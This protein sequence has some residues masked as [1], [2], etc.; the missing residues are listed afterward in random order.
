MIRRLPIALAISTTL[1]G[2]CALGP[3][4][5]RPATD[6]P[7]SF[8]T[9]LEKT[10]QQPELAD[11]HWREVFVDSE[12]QKLIA[13]ALSAGPDALLALARIREAEALAGVARAPLLPGAQL[14]LNTTPTARRSGD[15]F[16]SSYLGGLGL[17]WEIDL[18]GRYRRAGEAARAE[19]LASEE[20]RHGLNASLVA[21]VAGTY[22]QLAALREIQQVT[23]RAAENQREALR[24]VKRL[25]SAGISSAAEERQQESALGA[26]EARLP[27][28][29]R[30]IAQGENALA[31][32]LGRHPGSLK[33]DT[34]ARLEL[35]TFAP[36]DCLP[37][38]L[39]GVPTSARRKPG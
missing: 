14:Q 38:F 13:E 17:S 30:Q 33:L 7:S 6:L 26:T 4:Y 39:S 19:L 34:A 18:W 35:P 24:L 23:T 12:L 10:D 37:D 3:D 31:L 27:T 20:A 32:L 2:A 9:S 22:Y 16:T 25:S 8:Q 11:L 15:Q 1:L 28:L 29:R 21:S 5:Q 36:P